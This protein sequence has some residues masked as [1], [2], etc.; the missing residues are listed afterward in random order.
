M[1]RQVDVPVG[2]IIRLVTKTLHYSKGGFSREER[3]DLGLDLLLLASHVLEDIVDDGR[4]AEL[5]ARA[6]SAHDRG[7]SPDRLT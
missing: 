7:L 5:F 2:R 6:E 4:H 3:R 1:S